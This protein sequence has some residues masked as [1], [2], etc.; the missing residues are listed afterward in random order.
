[1]NGEVYLSDNS[2]N[3]V[4]PHPDLSDPVAA[5]G[6]DVVAGSKNVNGQITVVQGASY[7][8][9]SIEGV[10]IFGIL[11]TATVANRIWACGAGR[12][13]VVKIP[14]GTTALH[15]QTPSDS[16]R[17]ILRKLK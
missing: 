17:F 5:S 15:Y 1:M 11:T 9:T 4:P 14:V 2:G 7:A 3:R 13:I 6:Q 8:I 10:H 16:R 12:T